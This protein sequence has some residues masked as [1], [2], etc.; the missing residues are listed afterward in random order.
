MELRL[1]LPLILEPISLLLVL[2]CIDP[3]LGG[4]V[5]ASWDSKVETIESLPSLSEVS[6]SACAQSGVDLGEKPVVIGIVLLEHADVSF[7]AGDVH[8]LAGGIVIQVVRILN[9]RTSS[10]QVARVGVKNS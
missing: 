5:G 10:N 2:Y 6:G 3:N 4:M 1:I 7:S 8:T 9:R